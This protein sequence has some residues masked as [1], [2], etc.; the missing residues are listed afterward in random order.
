VQYWTP[1][2]ARNAVEN[3]PLIKRDFQKKNMEAWGYPDGIGLER[4]PKRIGR[5]GLV[6]AAGPSLNWVAPYLKR[7]QDGGMDIICGVSTISVCAHHGITPLAAVSVDSSDVVWKEQIEEWYDWLDE[8]QVPLV[9]HPGVNP[10]VASRWPGPRWWFLPEQV[11]VPIFDA[12]PAMFPQIPTKMLNAGC[13]ANTQ[14]EVCDFLGHKFLFTAGMDFGFTEGM[15]GATLYRPDGSSWER[16]H[17]LVWRNPVRMT[18]DGTY[19]TEEMLSYRLN[20]HLVIRMNF[21]QVARLTVG[22]RE[23]G[24][25]TEVPKVRVDDV[26]E[27]G[28][29]KI[30]EELWM[31]EEG[32]VKR[33]S[34]FLG[35]DNMVLAADD[36]GRPQVMHFADKDPTLIPLAKAVQAQRQA[37][38][39]KAREEEEKKEKKPEVKEE[40]PVMRVKI[41]PEQL[42]EMLSRGVAVPVRTGGE[43]HGQR[44]V[45]LF[46]GAL[47]E[48]DGGAPL[49][50]V[51]GEVGEAHTPAESS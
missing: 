15:F 48:K 28:W 19:T 18:K 10:V 42:K 26:L 21:T 17:Y 41:Q 29:E 45:Q 38:A 39:K 3:A 14:I 50:T 51:H 31:D 46:S 36:N 37:E 6:M 33:C 27:R 20:F 9:L 7:L 13:V 35:K 34:G 5:A 4:I 16:H 22:E 47:E 49:S 12:M 23:P 2:W 32:I 11:G 40:Q 8:K 25:V 24:I 30:A 44:D 43:V 1:I